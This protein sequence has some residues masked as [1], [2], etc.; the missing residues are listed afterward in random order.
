MKRKVVI[1][2][3][4]LATLVVPLSFGMLD[5]EQSRQKRNSFDIAK[6]VNLNGWLEVSSLDSAKLKNAVTNK[7]IDS[8]VLMGVDHVRI[9]I[10]ETNL[11]KNDLTLKENVLD[12]LISVIDYC[13]AQKIKVVVDLHESKDH[14]FGTT[15]ANLFKEFHAKERFFD[16]WKK[17]QDV[18]MHYPVDVLAYECLNEPAA[19]IKKHED[20][21]DLLAEWISLIRK[22]EPGRI[23]FVGSNRGNQIWTLKYLKIPKDQNLVFTFHFYS[24]VI[25]THY[26]K[27][28]FLKGDVPVYPGVPIAPRTFALLPDSL[29]KKYEYA[30]KDFSLKFIQSEFEKVHNWA[31]KNRIQVN[32]GEFGCRRFVADKSRFSWLSDVVSTAKSY[33]FSYTLWGLNGAGFGLR[34]LKDGYDKIMI[35]AME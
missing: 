12:A 20:W 11:L 27:D 15:E 5:L 22:K 19:S 10:S 29:K 32:L 33:A 30:Q 21:N 3:F 17:L 23:L 34:T 18:L 7:L 13:I 31:E 25:F 1:V 4:L 16:I 35:D 8:L 6:G 24:P 14:H 28:A 9:P 26:K 2:F